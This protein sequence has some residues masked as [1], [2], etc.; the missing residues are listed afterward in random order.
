VLAAQ[1]ALQLR[2]IEIRLGVVE[3]ALGLAPRI[4]VVLLGRELEQHPHVLECG[5]ERVVAGQLPLDGALLAQQLL[6][7][8]PIFPEGRVGGLGL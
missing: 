3:L 6:R 4:G 8:L 7:P 5:L 2:R 1:Q